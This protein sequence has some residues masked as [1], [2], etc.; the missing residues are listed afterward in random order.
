MPPDIRL[1]VVLQPDGGGQRD[2]GAVPLKAATQLRHQE[3]Q[4]QG[5]RCGGLLVGAPRLQQ[6]VDKLLGMS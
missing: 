6:N 1:L 2:D 3:V 4:L 5:V